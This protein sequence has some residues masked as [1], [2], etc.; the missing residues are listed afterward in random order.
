MRKKFFIKA[1]TVC[2]LLTL[3]SCNNGVVVE[4]GIE[5]VLPPTFSTAYSY[6]QR[7]VK[8]PLGTLY[9]II[10]PRDTFLVFGVYSMGMSLLK[11]SP[12]K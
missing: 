9:E 8:M 10:T 1:L 12:V 4:E 3:F 11:Q 7:V 6:K 2:L 5:G